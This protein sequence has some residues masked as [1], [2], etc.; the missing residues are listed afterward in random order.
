M[1]VTF[2]IAIYQVMI[3]HGNLVDAYS[4][5]ALMTETVGFIEILVNF[6]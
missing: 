5:S 6:L 1:A 4:S 3:L 2:L